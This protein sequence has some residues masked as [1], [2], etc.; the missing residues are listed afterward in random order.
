M[1]TSGTCSSSANMR[2]AVVLPVP[3]GPVRSTARGRADEISLLSFLSSSLRFAWLDVVKLLPPLPS[4]FS[5][6]ASFA[7]CFLLAFTTSL[8]TSECAITSDTVLRSCFFSLS[9]PASSAQLDRSSSRSAGKN[10]LTPAP[11][12][13]NFACSTPSSSLVPRAPL[14]PLLCWLA[15]PPK[16][17]GGENSASTSSSP[18]CEREKGGDDELS[19]TIVI[20]SPF[21]P[22]FSIVTL[23]S[24][25]LKD[26][27]AEVE[28]ESATIAPATNPATASAS[29]SR[30]AVPLRLYDTT[31]V[32]ANMKSISNTDPPPPVPSL[33][34]PNDDRNI[35]SNWR[36]ISLCIPPPPCTVMTIDRDGSSPS[37][38]Y[39]CTG[40]NTLS[41]IT[42]TLSW[43][44]TSR[45]RSC[46]FGTSI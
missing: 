39:S 12:N 1:S 21:S 46:S 17:E 22:T 43:R 41:F 11:S 6:H 33:L 42:S 37:N 18:P 7:L 16:W 5:C 40:P 35:A 26:V 30:K 8:S 44:E 36:K 15:F 19:C 29:D 9:Y 45:S 32:L 4:L 38:T 25:L 10:T 23:L 34:I 24:P 27:V 14:P 13:C 2:A 31:A 20:F 3:G 28:F